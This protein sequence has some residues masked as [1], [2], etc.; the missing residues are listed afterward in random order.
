ML[1]KTIPMGIVFF[2]IMEKKRKTR[3]FSDGAMKGEK[4]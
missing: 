2:A 3:G 4:T 1:K